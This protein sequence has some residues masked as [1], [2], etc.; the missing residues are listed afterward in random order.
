MSTKAAPTIA[1]QGVIGLQ[2]EGAGK[3]S[4]RNLWLKGL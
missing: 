4:F 2:I 1:A 3:I